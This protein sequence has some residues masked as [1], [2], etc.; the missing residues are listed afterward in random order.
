[1]L[2][3]GLPRLAVQLRSMF[4]DACVLLD[5]WLDQALDKGHDTGLRILRSTFPNHP[6]R[7]IVSR[8]FELPEGQGQFQFFESS[9]VLNY[10]CLQQISDD[11]F[12]RL[13]AAE[14]LGLRGTT[15]LALDIGASAKRGVVLRAGFIGQKGR[16]IDETENL[17]ID[18]L[19]LLRFAQASGRSYKTQLSGR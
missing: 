12:N 14:N 3:E 4:P 13:I 18:I 7:E 17:A 11:D 9:L 15:I 19:T 5:K 1:M 6:G 2:A 8:S 10:S 16:T